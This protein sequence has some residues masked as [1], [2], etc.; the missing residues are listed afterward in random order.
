MHKNELLQVS[1]SAKASSDISDANIPLPPGWQQHE[2]MIT[3]C[4]LLFE[5]N[6]IMFSVC[7][8]YFFYQRYCILLQS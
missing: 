1:E 5:F 2:G 3:A 7:Q 4:S 8:A 6:Y